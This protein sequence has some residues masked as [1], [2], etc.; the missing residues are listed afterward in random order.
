MSL[1][2]RVFLKNTL[3][4]SA[5]ALG[6]TLLPRAL[7]AEWPKAAFDAKSVDEALTALYKSKEAEKSDKIVIDAPDIAENGAVVKVDVSTELEKIE[8]IAIIAEKNPIPLVAEF[9]LSEN[10]VGF[11][12]T[13]IKMGESGNVTAIVKANGKLYTASKAVKVTVG[14][15]GG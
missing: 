2:R 7:W 8:S 9:K 6:A 1:S 4:G 10:T 12:S 15:C 11:V 13:R 14:G 3:V 5:V